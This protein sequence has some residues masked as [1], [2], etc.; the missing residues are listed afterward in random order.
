[1]LHSVSCGV[2]CVS[3]CDVVVFIVR[4][5]NPVECCI[6]RGKCWRKPAL[7]H[8][9]LALDHILSFE[10]VTQTTWNREK[11]VKHW[12]NIHLK[13]I[14]KA[15][16]KSPFLIVTVI[17]LGKH[18]LL[19]RQ[20]LNSITSRRV[21]NSDLLMKTIPILM[22]FIIV[23]FPEWWMVEQETCQAFVFVYLRP[24]C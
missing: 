22:R 5:S 9:I 2:W 20:Y 19:F 17:L 23:S 24:L 3:D 4:T 6:R 10:I 12:W 15:S 18:Y 8:N 16:V 14:W 1:M 11:K 7:Q 13:F 21:K